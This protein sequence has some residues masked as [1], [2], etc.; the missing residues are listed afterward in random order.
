MEETTWDGE[1]RIAAQE[2][3][4]VIPLLCLGRKSQ[5]LEGWL[6]GHW[7]RHVDGKETQRGAEYRQIRI[8]VLCGRI[9]SRAITDGTNKW[10]NIVLTVNVLQAAAFVRAYRFHQS[11]HYYLRR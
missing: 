2:V 9:Y 5:D 8:Y 3:A 11:T 6:R 7:C 4:Y 10:M 1:V